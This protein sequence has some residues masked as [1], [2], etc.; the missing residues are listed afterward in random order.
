M[1]TLLL[2]L[3]AI[4]AFAVDAR[5]QGAP[6][7][8]W[9]VYRDDMNGFSFRYPPSLQVVEGPVEPMHIEGLVRAVVVRDPASPDS[10]SFPVMYMLVVKCGGLAYCPDS[11]QLRTT[12]DRFKVL[13]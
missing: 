4:S 12:C 2:I 7:T 9:R 3:F 8:Q 1:R 13:P 6:D 5:G 10:R 11:K